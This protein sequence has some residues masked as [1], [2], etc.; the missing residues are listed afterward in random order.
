[1]PMVE[2]LLENVV[3][4][5]KKL[6]PINPGLHKE[7]EV[8]EEAEVVAEAEEVPV[9][10]FALNFEEIKVTYTEN[11]SAGKKKGNVEYSWK[12]EKGEA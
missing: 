12:V 2:T 7:A 11:D 9:E 3:V 6:Q 5:V 4:N 10:D 1:M 8:E